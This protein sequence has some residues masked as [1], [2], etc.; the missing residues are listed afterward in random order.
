MEGKREEKGR[1]KFNGNV[2]LQSEMTGQSSAVFSHW[3]W[4]CVGQL[5]QLGKAQHWAVGM[6]MESRTAP[7]LPPC[8]APLHRKTDRNRLSEEW[9]KE[10]N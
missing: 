9:K 7:S 2:L 10:R 4:S 8:K 6:E 3:N 1:E 5:A